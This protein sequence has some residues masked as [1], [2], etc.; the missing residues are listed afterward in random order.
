MELFKLDK[1]EFKDVCGGLRPSFAV[2]VVKRRW[3]R[4]IRSLVF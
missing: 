3:Q 4:L 2:S 1:A